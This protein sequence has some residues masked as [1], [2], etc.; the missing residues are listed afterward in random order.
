MYLL[1]MEYL[2]IPSTQ[3][4]APFPVSS[5]YQNYSANLCTLY[6]LHRASFIKILLFFFS[7]KSQKTISLDGN[8]LGV[9]DFR[10]MTSVL[11]PSDPQ[12]VAIH[13][14]HQRSTSILRYWTPVASISCFYFSTNISPVCESMSTHAAG[15]KV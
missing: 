2:E 6:W 5:H 10:L 3:T 11:V 14:C 7:D 1:N 9:I 4:K 12:E 8:S 13:Y 15:I